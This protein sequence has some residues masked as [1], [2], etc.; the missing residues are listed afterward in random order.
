MTVQSIGA[1][2]CFG[3]G[4]KDMASSREYLTFV[5]DQ[6][7]P[8]EVSYRQMMDE[9]VIYCRGKV[10]GGIYDDR[11]LVKPTPAALRLMPD[12]PRELPYE[13]AKEMLLV[14]NI[15]DRPFLT[16]LMNAMADELPPVPASG[17]TRKRGPKNG[18]KRV[19]LLNGPSSS[20]KSTLAKALKALIA[21]KLNARYEI[22]SIDD[23]MKIGTDETIYEDDV[24][25][26][27]GDM[28]DE[29]SELLSGAD[30]ADGVIVDHVITSERIFTQFTEAMRPYRVHTVRIVC[31][32][33]VLK[34]R[35]A[36]RGD[37]CRGSAEA[38]FEYL[39]PK[40]GYELS[41][42]TH[43]MTPEECAA[44]IVSGLGLVPLSRG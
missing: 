3:Y 9:Y 19:I 6:L 4:G 44:A 15:D 18:R 30:A 17:R 10:V 20:G 25:E 13:G 33:E 16:E 2:L 5:M 36:E 11:F 43:I 23:H 37:R 35:E 34:Q 28:L 29:V 14:E 26:I 42:D 27:S 38:S 8:A 12:A 7:S 1:V 40:E 41:V 32:I 31:P 24:F 39:Y 21:E 22:V